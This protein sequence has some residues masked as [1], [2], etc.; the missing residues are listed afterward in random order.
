MGWGFRVD[1]DRGWLHVPGEGD[2]PIA[3]PDLDPAL[4]AEELRDLA[5]D[6]ALTPEP[7]DPAPEPVR[8]AV[9]E[10]RYCEVGVLGPITVT[11]GGVDLEG[12]TPIARQL[13]TYLATQRD[14]VRLERLDAAIWPDRPPSRGGQ[15]ART[16]LT[17]LRST[18][19][20]GPDGEPLLPRREH[21]DQPVQLSP[22]VGTDLDRALQLLANAR[23]RDDPLEAMADQLAALELVRGNPS[24]T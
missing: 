3:L 21:A 1:G 19:G 16:A 10:P 8:V 6:D 22:H 2:Q 7:D 18:L 11:R 17:R 12:L 14:G 23:R 9:A 24:K 13:L 15:R 20:D 5:G 4:I